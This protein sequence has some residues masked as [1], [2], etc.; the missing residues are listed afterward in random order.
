MKKK[1]LARK[2]I[3]ATALSLALVLGT[4]GAVGCASGSLTTAAESATAASDDE[5]AESSSSDIPDAP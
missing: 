5:S 2:M 3:P 1:S 4:V